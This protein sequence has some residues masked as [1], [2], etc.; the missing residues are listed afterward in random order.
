[1]S[2]ELPLGL[3]LSFRPLVEIAYHGGRVENHLCMKEPKEGG[4]FYVTKSCC[5][6]WH[7][8]VVLYAYSIKNLAPKPYPQI[9][10]DPTGSL[11]FHAK[12]MAIN[13]QLKSVSKEM[14]DQILKR[15]RDHQ[16]LILVFLMTI[17][18]LDQNQ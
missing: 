6:C 4:L 3:P 9:D 15:V 16:P 14:S 17:S 1:M 11:E 8:F 2:L 18:C 13:N 12:C 10:K 5:Y 7:S